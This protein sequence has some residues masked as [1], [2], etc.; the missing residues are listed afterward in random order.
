[1]FL[2]V[3]EIMSVVDRFGLVVE[4]SYLTIYIPATN[5]ALVFRVVSRCNRGFEVFDYG[6]LPLKT[7]DTLST[8]AG[9]TTTVPADGVLPAMGIT[10]DLRFPAIPGTALVN[11]RDSSDIWYLDKDD[12]DRLFH[13]KMYIYPPVIRTYVRIPTNV[14]QYRFQKDRVALGIDAPLGFSRGLLEVVHI[15]YLIYGYRFAND[16]NLDLRT[17]VKFVFAEY[18]VEIPRK[19]DLVFDILTRRVPSYWLT[20]PI[21]SL[22]PAIKSALSDVYGFREPYWG[23]RLYR[24]DER[25]RAIREYEEVLKVLKV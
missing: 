11:V 12:R 24:A 14:T 25:D 20:M 10:G 22:E 2:V 3:R 8:F 7:G 15:P 17:F 23:F 4:N 16:T 18:I 19:S 6:S 9:G 1:V 13:V 21:A 5:S